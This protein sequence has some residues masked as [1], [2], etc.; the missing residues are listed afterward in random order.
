MTLFKTQALAA[1]QEISR[2]KAELAGKGASTS[3]P[4]Q[5][6]AQPSSTTDGGKSRCLA[7][8]EKYEAMEQGPERMAFLRANRADIM[9]GMSFKG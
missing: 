1:Q 3:T 4:S 5:P 6:G 7:V 2:L 8:L 9:M